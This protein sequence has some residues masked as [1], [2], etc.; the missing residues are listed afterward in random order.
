MPGL[1]A[2]GH[3][4]EY[5]TD[6]LTD[7]AEKFIEQN[8]DRPFF[9]YFAHYAVHMPLQ[10][11]PAVLEK[12]KAKPPVGGQK[13]PIY[14]AMVES[15]DDSVGRIRRKLQSLGIADRTVVVF[16]SDNG[17]Y[18]PHATSNAPLRAGKG[19]PVRGRHPRAADR[20]VAGDDQARDDV[21]VPVC[22]IDFFPTLLEIAGVKTAGRGGRSAVSSPC[23]SRPARS[24]ATRS[25][26][27]TRITGAAG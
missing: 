27:I 10:A 11:K 16:M 24:S 5:L 3:E 8:R 18:W 23:S 6:R 22:S 25:T 14:A 12:Y 4:G 20:Q 15:V 17:G 2:G 26:G 9:L 7:E 19:Y 1:K 13:N 21:P